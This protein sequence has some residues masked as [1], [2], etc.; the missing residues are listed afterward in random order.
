MSPPTLLELA[1]AFPKGL[2]GVTYGAGDP[3]VSPAALEG[4]LSRVAVSR[5]RE[6][7]VLKGGV[8]LAAFS[9]RDFADIAKISATHGVGAGDLPGALEALATFR[10]ATLRTLLSALAGMPQQVQPKWANWRRRQSRSDELPERFHDDLTAAAG[11][12]MSAASPPQA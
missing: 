12:V 5:F 10:G 8:L 9:L 3:A 11:R 7:F 2:A 6:G 4:L 1:R